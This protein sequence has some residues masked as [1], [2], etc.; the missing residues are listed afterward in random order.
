MNIQI[1]SND[2]REKVKNYLIS[3]CKIKN[4]T[5]ADIHLAKVCITLLEHMRDTCCLKKVI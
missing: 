3:V 2:L 1:S 5:E 4:P